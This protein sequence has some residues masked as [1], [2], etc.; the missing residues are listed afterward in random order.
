MGII[1]ER[2]ALR[3]RVGVFRD[4]AEAGKELA[5]ELRGVVGE[6]SIILAIPAGGVPV[7]AAAADEL[8]LAFDVIIVRKIQLPYESEAGFGAVGPE[9]EVILDED[10][11]RG[12]NLSDREIEAQVSVTKKSRAGR[13]RAFRG[14]ASFPD[15]RR[16]QVILVDDGLATGSTMLAAARFVR[17]KGASSTVVAVPTASMRAI[18]VLRQEVDEIL[19]PNVRSGPYFAVADA[20]IDWHDVAEEEAISFLRSHRRMA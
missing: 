6:E 3:N 14:D 5:K 15:L 1:R 17:K 16:K 18:E 19:C 13:E 20:Y 8:G 9:D 4:R 12:L 7:A 10:L 2:A 11:V